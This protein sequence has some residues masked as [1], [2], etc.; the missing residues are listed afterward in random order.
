M[1]EFE[2]HVE[3]PGASRPRALLD[4]CVDPLPEDSNG[5]IT[6]RRTRRGTLEVD[7]LGVGREV[8]HLKRYEILRCVG[9]GGM[10][11]VYQAYDPVLRRDIALKVMKPDVPESERRRFRR[12]AIYGARFCHP[13]I[14]RVYDMG[15]MRGNTGAE[16][17]SMEYLAGSD[18]DRVVDR[19][20]E[21]GCQLPL[22]SVLDVFR[23]VLAALQYCHDC[24]VVHRD[25]K[26]ANMFVTRDPNTR[27][28]TTKLLDFGIA[29]DLD[30]QRS[31]ER[32]C[33]DPFYMAP[34]QTIPGVAVDPRADVYSAGIS[35][36]E[37][38]T[39]LHPFGSLR[40][41][42]LGDIFAAQREHTP[43]PLSDYLPDHTSTR[44]ARGLD[45]I[46]ERAC[47]KDRDE[48]FQSARDMQE[49]LMVVLTPGSMSS[50][51]GF[52]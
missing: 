30:E 52:G 44:V 10:G 24:G 32:L 29:I 15:E 31:R 51:M 18:L 5:L 16:W 3:D 45:M 38:I 22:L 43:P 47:A 40:D 19:A 27:F 42:P 14:A 28:M 34:E 4:A 11:R 9:E 2:I 46:F 7:D 20:R 48:R 23:Q 17:F 6:R 36:Y 25:I 50:G 33:G 1:Q 35:L 37:V 13:S 8:S 26:P 21:R 12:E 39:G 49:A 41:A